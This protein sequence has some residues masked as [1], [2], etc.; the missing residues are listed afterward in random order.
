MRAGLGA[1]IEMVR[2]ATV[3]I[4]ARTPGGARVPV[5]SGFFVAPGWVLS[6]AHV[7]ANRADLRVVWH[8]REFTPAS[9]TCEPKAHN[10]PGSWPFP[11]AAV[12]HLEEL[13]Q[14]DTQTCVPVAA[15]PPPAGS[16]VW[17]YGVSAIRTGYAERDGSVLTVANA[18]PGDDELIRLQGGELYAGM[19][20]GPVLSLDTYEVCAVTKATQQKGPNL[21]GW[22]VPIGAVMDAVLPAVCL[23]ELNRRRHAGGLPALR[24]D[25][26]TLG[27]LPELARAALLDRPGAVAVLA[28]HLEELGL[29][30]PP[31]REDEVAEWVARRLFALDLS[32]LLDALR[33]VIDLLGPERTLY[34]FDVVACSLPV[35]DRPSWWISGDAALALDA[36]VRRPAPRMVRIPSDNDVTV[37]LLLWRAFHVRPSVL[38]PVGPWS[39][40]RS[41]EAVPPD[42]R[43]DIEAEIRHG[44]GLTDEDWNDRETRV[45]AV[46]ELGRMQ[47]FVQVRLDSP[48]DAGLLRT[49]PRAFPGLRLFVRSR[50]LRMPD[51]VDDVVLD[52]LPAGDAASESTGLWRRRY[53]RR[54]LLG[55]S[56]DAG[57]PRE[58]Q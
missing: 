17:V 5:G 28:R 26:L 4:T 12:L 50:S 30:A 13:A 40:E 10:G 31:L 58:E 47:A 20:G 23:A 2:S 45:R 3:V 14:D 25:Q 7:V 18:P 48:P 16:R 53:L 22:A 33:T 46:A 1:I 34:V 37:Y 51:G 27:R 44:L 6:C 41:A 36:E 52:L 29:A 57:W 9:V 43:R 21:G 42:L 38:S 11:D 54:N 32:Q 19:S 56:A 35:D 39:G 49:L 24:Q 15:H 55:L 8:G